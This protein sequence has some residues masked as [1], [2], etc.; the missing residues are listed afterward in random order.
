M[1]FPASLCHHLVAVY[2]LLFFRHVLHHIKLFQSPL[3]EVLFSF[4]IA[5]KRAKS[6][7]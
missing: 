4:T 5:A 1:L 3:G 2:K 7:I 6:I